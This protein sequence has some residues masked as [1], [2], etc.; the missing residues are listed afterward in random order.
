MSHQPDKKDHAEQ[1]KQDKAAGKHGETAELDSL[2]QP[3]VSAKMERDNIKDANERA[4]KKEAEA[5]KEAKTL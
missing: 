3:N 5:K 2:G 1:A 4:E